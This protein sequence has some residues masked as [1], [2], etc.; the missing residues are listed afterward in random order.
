VVFYDSLTDAAWVVPCVDVEMASKEGVKQRG[1]AGRRSKRCRHCKAAA[2]D[3]P[4]LTI[5]PHNLYEWFLCENCWL[6]LEVGFSDVHPSENLYEYL[7][8]L[9]GRPSDGAVYRYLLRGRVLVE[10]LARLVP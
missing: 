4:V 2:V 3:P 9:D 1:P 10:R 6:L 7:T 8:P 5:G